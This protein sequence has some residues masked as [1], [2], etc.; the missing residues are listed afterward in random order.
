MTPHLE[1]YWGILTAGPFTDDEFSDFI[2]G[3]DK[4]AVGKG[5]EPP[6]K[7][8]ENKIWLAWLQ[9]QRPEKNKLR[10]QHA[11][12][13]CSHVAEPVPETVG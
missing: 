6:G 7:P 11:G 3:E 1:Q 2:I 5:T 13:A 10:Q 12:V 8:V 4:N 9:L